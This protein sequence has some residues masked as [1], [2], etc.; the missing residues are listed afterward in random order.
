MEPCATERRDLGTTAVSNEVGAAGEMA[1]DVATSRSEKRVGS[2]GRSQLNWYTRRAKQP[3]SK[4]EEA[5]AISK[6]G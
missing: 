4:G 5:V 1:H 6:R 2:S 3:I